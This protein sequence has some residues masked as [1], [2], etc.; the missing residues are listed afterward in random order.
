M[1]VFPMAGLSKRFTQKGYTLPK[2][3][4]P[5]WDGYV[6]DFA[7]SSFRPRFAATPFL[8]I[9]RET[10][11]VRSFLSAR[12]A[13]LGIHDAR[14]VELDRTTA[15]QAETVALGVETANAG[16]AS[17][18]TIFNIDTFRNP[19]ASPF[20]ISSS[21]GGWLEVFK[22]EGD[23]WSF[24]LPAPGEPGLAA[25]TAEK[26]AISDLCCSGLYHF[27]SIELFQAA[28][29]EERR[30][31]SAAELYVAPIY[32]HMIKSGQRVGYGLI[33]PD[34]LVHC[35]LPHEYEALLGTQQPWRGVS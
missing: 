27:A 10:G 6:F 26:V 9:F 15:G 30:H 21:L 24:V 16:S 8:F 28:L 14:F 31:P 1:I 17:P 4:L 11:G 2:Y 19:S 12:A 29:A 5:L 22:G 34:D 20:P 32:N 23:N 33:S 18:L 35:G 25:K 13:A 7:V 3:M